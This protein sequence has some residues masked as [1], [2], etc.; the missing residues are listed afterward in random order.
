MKMLPPKTPF[1]FIRSTLFFIGLVLFTLVYAMLSLC[2]FPFSYRIRSRFIL[3]WCNAIIA[4]LKM[5]CGVHYKIIGQD[6]IPKQNVIVLSKHQ[7]AWETFMLQI[8]FPLSATVLKKELLKIPLYGW[9]LAL[10][11]PIAIDRSQKTSAMEQ[12]ITQGK[13]RLADGRSI[14]IFPE[15]TRVAP[16]VNKRFTRGGATLA[17]ASEYPVLP[18]AHNAGELWPRR[19]FIKYPGTIKMIIG[20]LI[21]T[22]GK[23]AV[24]I[25][26]EVKAWLNQTMYEHFGYE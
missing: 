15:G 19:S 25:N 7:S 23:T 18:I 3:V 17:E 11:E 26:Q 6:N 21:E 12:I 14:L 13:Q 9:A 1:I 22:K 20:P 10:L 24:E 8:L 16:G 2:T 4:W 5:T